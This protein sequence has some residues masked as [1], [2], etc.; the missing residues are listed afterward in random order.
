MT[1]L[2][3]GTPGAF[4]TDDWISPIGGWL[5]IADALIAAA[6]ARNPAMRLEE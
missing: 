5:L 2:I 6:A 4:I 3:T 1:F